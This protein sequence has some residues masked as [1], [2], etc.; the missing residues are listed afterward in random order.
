MVLSGRLQV[1]DGAIASDTQI[2]AISQLF[3]DHQQHF[4][5]RGAGC[6]GISALNSTQLHFNNL[7]SNL[8]SAFHGYVERADKVERER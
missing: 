3:G 2:L 4:N 5:R 8:N 7:N 1:G 6:R